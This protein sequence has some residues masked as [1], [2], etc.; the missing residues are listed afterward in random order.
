MIPTGT[1]SALGEKF[2]FLRNFQVP[3]DLAA[4]EDRFRAVASLE[5]SNP[6]L[7]DFFLEN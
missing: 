3:Q 6:P 7:S 2:S 4:V 5:L 1:G